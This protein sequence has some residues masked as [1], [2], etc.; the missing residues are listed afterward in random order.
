MSYETV[1][2]VEKAFAILEM[3]CNRA[4]H[5]R[6]V[7][8]KAIS[9]ELGI[10]PAT[11]RNLLRTLESLNYI[12]RLGHGKYIEGRRFT[13]LHRMGEARNLAEFARPMM[14]RGHEETG[15]SF[16]LATIRSGKRLELLRVGDSR[17]N[18]YEANVDFYRMRT[19]RCVLAWYTPEQLDCFLQIS[20]LPKPEEW[21]EAA[22]SRAELQ[23]ALAAVRKAGGC[24]D[25]TDG[26]TATAVPV[27]SATG[28]VCASIGCYSPCPRTDALRQRGVFQLLQGYADELRRFC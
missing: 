24:Q 26:M 28:E 21:P 25:V 18:G 14:E 3:I 20:G 9:N 13:E 17:G 4:N 23:K 1:K 19:T 27:F 2:S 12:K 10:L 5:N 11:S 15:E 22:G 6:A 16:V 7:S 8:L